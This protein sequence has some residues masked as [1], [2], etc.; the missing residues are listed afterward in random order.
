MDCAVCVRG[1]D[2]GRCRTLGRSDKKRTKAEHSFLQYLC[3]ASGPGSLAQNRPRFG[4]GSGPRPQHA[5][6]QRD[7]GIA[8]GPQWGHAVATYYGRRLM[9]VG[10]EGFPSLTKTQ[11][12]RAGEVVRVAVD[13]IVCPVAVEATIEAG[14]A[15]PFG[16]AVAGY[17]ARRQ[18]L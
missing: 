7:G 16:R 3:P 2:A 12:V 9:C 18:P 14:V 11:A 13:E 15:Q 6:R 10:D 8:S 5:D 17:A 4:S 1:P